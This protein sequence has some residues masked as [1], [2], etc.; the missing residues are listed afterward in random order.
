MIDGV[1]LSD[2]FVLIQGRLATDSGDNHL[3]RAGIPLRWSP[4]EFL[5]EPN[6][7]F[8]LV[9]CKMRG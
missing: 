9:L 4:N 6:I 1:S 8:Q 2:C 3:C 7:W 5:L